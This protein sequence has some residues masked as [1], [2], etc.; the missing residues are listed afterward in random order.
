MMNFKRREKKMVTYKRNPTR[1]SA[2]S[3]FFFFLAE[4]AGQKSMARYIKNA[5]RKKKKKNRQTRRLYPA[6]LAF[7]IE[8]EIKSSTNES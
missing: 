3:F 1:L 4:T 8:R 7:R 2:D 5:E 6:R